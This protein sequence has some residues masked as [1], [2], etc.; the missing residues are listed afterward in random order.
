M[1]EE[2]IMNLIVNAGEARSKSLLALRAAKNKD[3]ELCDGYLK[4]ASAA[5]LEAHK[6]QTE[7]IQ[8]EAAGEKQEVTLIMVHA[9]DH[10]MNALAIRDLVVEMVDYIKTAAGGQ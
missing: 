4:Q 2:M 9:Q 10:L 3:F 5:C 1:D 7:L 8:K 6:Q